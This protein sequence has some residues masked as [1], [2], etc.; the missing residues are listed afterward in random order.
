MAT[1]PPLATVV[2][3]AKVKLKEVPQAEETKAQEDKPKTS[4][5]TKKIENTTTEKKDAPAK[6]TKAKTKK[7]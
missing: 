4:G 7:G 5:R 6:T 1:I 2:W 3:K